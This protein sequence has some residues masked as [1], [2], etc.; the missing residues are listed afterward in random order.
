MIQVLMGALGISMLVLS[1][2]VILGPT[3]WDKLLVFNTISSNIV[4]LIICLAIINEN[5]Y[6]YDIGITY[7]ILG[8]CTTVLIARFIERREN[9]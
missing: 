8:F 6:F 3:I 4:V 5:T 1:I 7:A 9:L 2:R